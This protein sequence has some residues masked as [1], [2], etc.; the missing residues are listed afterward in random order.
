MGSDLSSYWA[1]IAVLVGFM[2]FFRA[3]SIVMLARRLI[4]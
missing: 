1:N 3:L 4:K 2:L